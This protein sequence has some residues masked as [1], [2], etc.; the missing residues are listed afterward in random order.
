MIVVFFKVDFFSASATTK[1]AM[2]HMVVSC[3]VVL[4]CVVLCCVVLCFPAAL[5]DSRSREG[6]ELVMAACP[7]HAAIFSGKTR[8]DEE[9]VGVKKSG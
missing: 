4:C 2:L 8:S 6:K 1:K 9:A 7:I 5:S 3:C